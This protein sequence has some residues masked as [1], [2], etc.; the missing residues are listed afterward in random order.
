MRKAFAVA[1]AVL[2]LLATADSLNPVREGLNGTDHPNATFV[3]PAAASTLDPQPSNDRLS[4]A[5]NGRP[6][7]QFSATWAGSMLTMHDGAYALATIPDDGS[8]VY[9]DGQLVVDNGGHRV[10]PAVRPAPS[11]L[12]RGVHAISVRFAQE[13][14]EG[15]PFHFDPLGAGTASR[16]N[17]IPAWALTPR[18]ERSG[19]S[20]SAPATE[21]GR[22]GVDVDRRAVVVRGWCGCGRG[23]GEGGRGSSAS[24]C[25]GRS[26]GFWRLAGA[27]CRL[28][29]GGDCRAAAGP[30]TNASPTLVLG[31]AARRLFPRLVRSYPP[32]HYYVLTA[33]FSPLLLLERWGRVDLVAG[34]Y[35][36]WR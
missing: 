25:G 4:A 10:W 13:G 18:R 26:G 8:W 11:R 33:A 34:P 29:S 1:T 30:P 31:G 6:P 16:S 14:G 7:A 9:V 3:D 21:R 20:A 19:R 28:A 36:V 15:A 17:A 5:W 27:E 2:A 24:R 32:F 12:T 23:S 35:A 22:G